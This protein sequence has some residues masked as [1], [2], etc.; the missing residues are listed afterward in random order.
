MLSSFHVQEKQM[1]PTFN[2]STLTLEIKFQLQ[3]MEILTS[4]GELLVAIIDV[5][6]RGQ[7][8]VFV[9]K[10]PIELCGAVKIDL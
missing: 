3:S 6:L 8:Q 4:L 10:W 9:T 1:A 7:S 2:L 5:V